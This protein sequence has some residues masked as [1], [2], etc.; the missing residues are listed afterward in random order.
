MSAPPPPPPPGPPPPPA[1]FTPPPATKGRNDLLADIR[2]GKGLKKVPESQ[3]KRPKDVK[4]QF[5]GSS[6]GGGGGGG[7]G[8]RADG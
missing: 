6:G 5:K 7:G 4:E 2:K 8:G 3:K 1:T